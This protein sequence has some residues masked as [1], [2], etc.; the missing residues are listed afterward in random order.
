[1]LYCGKC[2]GLT[3]RADMEEVVVNGD[4][5]FWCRPCAKKAK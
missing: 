4:P 2:R 3:E 1:M 5:I